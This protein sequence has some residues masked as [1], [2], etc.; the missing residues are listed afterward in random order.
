MHQ[1]SE[2]FL[3]SDLYQKYGLEPEEDALT[4]GLEV[5]SSEW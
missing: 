4:T 2:I 3:F 5:G 1:K